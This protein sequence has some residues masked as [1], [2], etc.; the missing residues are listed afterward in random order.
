[1]TTTEVACCCA[2]LLCLC[3]AI[4]LSLPATPNDYVWLGCVADEG[5]EGKPGLPSTVLGDYALNYIQPTACASAAKRAGKR[6]FGL[7]GGGCRAGTSLINA[8]RHSSKRGKC[9]AL[10]APDYI[11]RGGGRNPLSTSL[12]VLKTGKGEPWAV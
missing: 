4:H 5:D 3:C 1:M 11:C 6:F 2:V 10:C 12:Y 7:Q 8:L 9:T